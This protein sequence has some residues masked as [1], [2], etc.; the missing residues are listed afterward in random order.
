MQWCCSAVGTSCIILMAVGIVLLFLVVCHASRDHIKWWISSSDM[1]YKL[2]PQKEIKWIDYQIHPVNWTIAVNMNKKFQTMLGMG[3][4]FEP[5][6]CYNIMQMNEKNREFTIERLVNPVTGIGMNLMRLCIGTPDYTK[7]PWYTYDDVPKGETD[8][9][10]KLFSVDKDLDYIIP[11]IKIAM[12]KN[13]GLLFFASPWSPP[14]WMKTTA[15]IAGGSLLKK[16]YSSYALYLVSYIKAYESH[17]IPIYAVTIQNEPGVDTS[18]ETNPKERYPSCAWTADEE[19]DFIKDYL[20][21]TFLKYNLS[22]LIWCYDHNYNVQADPFEG[23]PGL[24]FPRTILSD[25]DAAKYV[26]GVAFHGYSGEPSGM[27]LFRNEFPSHKIH[28]SEGSYLGASGAIEMVKLLRNWASSYNAWVTI[29]D[30]NLMPNNGPFDSDVTIITLDAKTKKPIFNSDFYM[31]GQFMKFIERGSIRIETFDH[32]DLSD[33]AHVGFL[34]P[35][36][37]IVLILA[38]DSNYTR[39]FE[40]RFMDKAFV[41][42]IPFNSTVTFKWKIAEA[43]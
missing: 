20:G 36:N 30:S 7:D 15:D 38:S 41:A 6:T 23:D 19:R 40:I 5:S 29:L 28:F 42:E 31:Y 14:G 21:P 12:K 17:G 22:T 33:F 9:E 25:P 10:L 11:V 16:W 26:E 4:S 3:S 18:R 34:S 24:P 37:E 35:D 13:P 32:S 27:T 1:K 8:P 43:K 39:K 2:S